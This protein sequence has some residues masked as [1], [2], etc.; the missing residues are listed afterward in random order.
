[1]KVIIQL[2]LISALSFAIPAPVQDLVSLEGAV[3][4]KTQAVIPGARVT[5]EDSD[6]HI[7]HSTTADEVGHFRI[8]NVSTGTYQLRVQLRGFESKTQKIV[9]ANG[10]AISAS[11]E[12]DVEKVSQTVEVTAEEIYSESQAVTATKMNVPLL[13]IPQTVNVVNNELIRA[14]GATSMQDALRNVPAVSVHLG[15]GRRD[16]VLI[17]GFSALNDQYID[18]VRDDSPYYRDLS[19]VDRIEVLKGPAAV[20]YGRGSSGGII[21][22]VIKKAE[23]EQPL[24]FEF[25]TTIGS[26][27]EKRLTTDMGTSFLGDKLA[28]RLTGA[29]EDTNSF[30]HFYGL[31]R[32]D[33]SPSLAW[34]ISENTSLRFQA[35]HLYDGRLPD[36]GVPSLDGGPAPVDIHTYYGYPQDDFIRNR[37]NTQSLAFEH[38]FQHWLVRTNFRHSGYDNIF[39]NTQ[40]A[41]ITAEGL[42]K[43]EQYNVNSGQGN[44]FNQTEA[45]VG[46]RFAGLLHSALVGVEY[47]HQSRDTMRFTGTAGSV[48]LIDP[49]LTQPIYSTTPSTNNIFTGSLVGIY[50]NDQVTIHPKWKA[51]VGVRFDHYD[52]TLDDR[53]AANADLGRTDNAFS[54]RA[55]LVYQPTS[56]SSIYG[57]YSRSFQPSG[58]GLSLAVNNEELKPETSENFELGSKF[59]LFNRK[60]ST[61]FSLFRLNRS[62]VKTIDPNDSTKLVLAGEQR[63]NGFEWSFSGTVLKRWNVYG[64]YA[65]L[66]AHII[67]ANDATQGKRIALVSPNAF[68]LWS[69]YAFKNGFGFG[70]GIIYNDSRYAGNDN[71]VLLPDYTRVDATVFWKK[72]KYDVVLNLRNVGNVLYYESAQNNFQVLPGAPV[73][74]SM[75]VRYKW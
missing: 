23:I 45:V 69:T 10:R 37:V 33:L 46:G 43:R 12:L 70:G 14:Q 61:T 59:D 51:S 41:G 17:R 72:R 15:E 48:A 40:P 49:V 25:G 66:D 4:D 35:E 57:S 18:G 8:E 68:N 24:M 39:S 53:R 62:N 38:R 21:N 67:R 9:V 19:S 60:L 63:T 58:D 52:Q 71:I 50:V 65:Y 47:G 42:V 7:V 6:G 16:Q 36:R 26:Y 3:T 20:L 13:D 64:G 32:Y 34:K 56:W 54:P 31:N 1:M 11:V 73:N 29:Y 44:F 22:R 28:T 75:T 74:G 2:L 5:L 55:G 27:G 30:R